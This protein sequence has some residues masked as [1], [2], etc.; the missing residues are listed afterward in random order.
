[1][2]NGFKWKKFRQNRLEDFGVDEN[3]R[4]YVVCTNYTEIFDKNGNVL[5][6]VNHGRWVSRVYLN[7]QD[8]LIRFLVSTKGG[9]GYHEFVI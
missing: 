2:R 3:N 6:K 9:E 8:G 5:M 1:M 7:F 4:L